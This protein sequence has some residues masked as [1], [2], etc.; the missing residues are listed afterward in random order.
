MEVLAGGG[1]SDVVELTVALAREML[2]GAG[3]TGAK[4]PADAL[5]DGSAMDAWRRMITA[6]GGDPD[7]PLPVARESHELTAPASGVLSR[8]DAYGVG[9]AVL[10]PWR[11]PGSQGGPGVLHGAAS[12]CTPSPATPSAKAS[13]Y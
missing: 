11:R 13:H 5:R 4:D 6:Q 12:P 9:V 3:L 8:L 1:P 2:A 7:A 10:A